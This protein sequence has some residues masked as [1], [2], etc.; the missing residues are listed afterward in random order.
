MKSIL[1]VLALVLSAAAVANETGM[2]PNGPWTV[3]PLGYTDPSVSIAG[4]GVSTAGSSVGSFV[5][6][7]TLGSTAGSSAALNLKAIAVVVEN[8]AQNYLQTGEMSNILG[9]EVNNILTQNSDLS[10]E[11]AV[12]IVLQFAETHI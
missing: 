10:V 7:P 3:G 2:G 4:A 8:D 12:S 9:Y 11:E 1:I 5:G 6:N